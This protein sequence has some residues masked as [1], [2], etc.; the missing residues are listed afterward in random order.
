MSF[1]MRPIIFIAAH[2]ASGPT[3]AT[4]PTRSSARNAFSSSGLENDGAS[5]T[6][7]HEI[8]PLAAISRTTLAPMLWPTTTSA[9]TWE[10]SAPASRTQPSMVG[11]APGGVPPN[12]GSVAATSRASWRAGAGRGGGGEPCLLEGRLV[13]EPLVEG[14]RA[15]T[16]RQQERRL[17]RVGG[18]VFV[19]IPGHGQP[20]P[21]CLD[22]GAVV[23][24]LL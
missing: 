10:A 12:P 23:D 6:R 7:G 16:A 14:R 18:A 8:R 15:H 11:S 2:Q 4:R 3:P 19:E 17:R 21:A 22:S 5:R 1:A 9:P 13:R 20:Y 24:N